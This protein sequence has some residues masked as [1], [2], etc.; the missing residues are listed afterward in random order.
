VSRDRPL[1]AEQ[2]KLLDQLSRAADPSKEELEQ[3]MFQL[4]TSEVARKAFGAE[5]VRLRK[6]ATLARANAYY[7]PKKLKQELEAMPKTKS[8]DHLVALADAKGEPQPELDL[9]S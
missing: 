3:L 4:E 9:T 2:K 5:L 8:F 1:T 7:L 6:L